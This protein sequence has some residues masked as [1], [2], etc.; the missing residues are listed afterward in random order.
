MPCRLSADDAT[1][2]GEE[3]Q[4]LSHAIGSPL[5]PLSAW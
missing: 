5:R 2:V 4:L 3:Q 1:I